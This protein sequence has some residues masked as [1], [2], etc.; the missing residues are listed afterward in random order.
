MCSARCCI[1]HYGKLFLHLLKKFFICHADIL[2]GA[3]GRQ[4]QLVPKTIAMTHASCSWAIPHVRVAC[5]AAEVV[6]DTAA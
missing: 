3:A 1:N 5:E 4:L 6:P 2:C